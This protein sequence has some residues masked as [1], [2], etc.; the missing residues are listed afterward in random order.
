M[1][2][3]MAARSRLQNASSMQ[4]TM[5]WP[6]IQKVREP[7]K[8]VDWHQ[9]FAWRP[10]TD[11]VHVVWLQKVWRRT[12]AAVTRS[13]RSVLMVEYDVGCFHP[14]DEVIFPPDKNHVYRD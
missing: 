9:W 11:G 2:A 6:K 13:G 5:M 3:S 12:E 4:A 7:A 8:P 10:V 14:Y 1:I